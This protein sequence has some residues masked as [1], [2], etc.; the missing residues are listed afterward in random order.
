MLDFELGS[1]SVCFWNAVLHYV[2]LI[3]GHVQSDA[4]IYASSLDNICMFAYVDSMLC[5]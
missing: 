2:L 4:K 3:A 1:I 5:L